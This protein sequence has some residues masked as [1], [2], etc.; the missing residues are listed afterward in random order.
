M[1]DANRQAWSAHAQTWVH[2]VLHPLQSGSAGLSE[3][4]H[5]L[6]CSTRLTKGNGC[7]DDLHLA[8]EEIVLDLEKQ[9]K[10][11]FK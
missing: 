3:S 5:E 11:A 1:P 6:Q 7:H 2:G 9:Q 8:R 4:V 10:S